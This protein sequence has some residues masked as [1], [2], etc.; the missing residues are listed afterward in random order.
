MDRTH[1]LEYLS[2][3]IAVSAHRSSNVTSYSWKTPQMCLLWAELQAAQLSGGTQGEVPQLSPVYGA[4]EQHLY[5]L[6]GVSL[7]PPPTLLTYFKLGYSTLSG[8]NIN[9]PTMLKLQQ[10]FNRSDSILMTFIQRINVSL[11]M[12]G[13]HNILEC[14][15]PVILMGKTLYSVRK[16]GQKKVAAYFLG[17][18]T[19]LQ[20]LLLHSVNP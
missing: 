2:Q 3:C 18:R 10:Y 9:T 15:Y 7:S 20:V 8:S 6:V 19:G 16:C 13:F 17:W 5:R 11:Q 14:S 4:A 12:Q 1:A